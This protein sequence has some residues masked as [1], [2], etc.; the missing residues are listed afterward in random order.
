MKSVRGKMFVFFLHCSSSHL[1]LAGSALCD[2]GCA[3]DSWSVAEFGLLPTFQGWLLALA[4][5][6]VLTWDGNGTENE[7]YCRAK[8]CNADKEDTE[9]RN[10]NTKKTWD[11]GC[12]FCGF[13]KEA[14]KLV[15][16]CMVSIWVLWVLSV[17]QT[18]NLE[19]KKTTG[20]VFLLIVLCSILCPGSVGSADV[21]YPFASLNLHRSWMV[22]KSALMITLSV[23]LW[24]CSCP[25]SWMNRTVHWCTN[26]GQTE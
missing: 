22:A 13:T 24:V 3:E 6:H 9:K 5:G 15:Q 8:S 25:V 20:G 10:I 16:I 21:S 7:V 26:N 18:V 14:V 2:L 17:D 19:G 4:K 11:L 12:T 1:L 23:D